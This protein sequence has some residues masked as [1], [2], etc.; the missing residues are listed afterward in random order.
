[1]KKEGWP[2]GLSVVVP[3]AGRKRK[4]VTGGI[5]TVKKIVFLSSLVPP[6]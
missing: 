2:S 1:M 3:R 6:V 4:L 5:N